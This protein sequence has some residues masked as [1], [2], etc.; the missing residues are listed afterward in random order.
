MDDRE[1]K[2][3]V[4]P[5]GEGKMNWETYPPPR[6]LETI[7]GG[8]EVRWEEDLGVSMHGG[9]A[10]FIEFLNVSGIWKRFVAECPLKY[11]SPNAPTN[12]EILG[13]ILFSVL[14]GHR[15]Y[16]HITRI[17][18]DNVLPGL[19]GI[20]TLRSE[21]SVRRAFEEQKEED[22][23]LWMD[24]Q[25]NETYE[26]LLDQEWILDLDATVK[27][28]YGRQEEAQV[29]Y[30][31]MKPGRPSH[32]YHAMVMTAAKLVIN[33]DAE[34]G[35]RIASAYAQPTLWGWL[36][37]REKK[38]WPTLIRGDIAY[39]NE[40]MMSGC[41]QRGLG[42]LFKLRQ[43]PRVAQMLGS[44]ARNRKAEWHNAGQG[45]EG[46]EQQLQ[47]Q[48]WSVARRV[49]VLRRKIDK[50]RKVAANATQLALP[51]LTLQHRDGEQ[52][53]HAVLVTC[54][55]ERD[56]L[57]VAQTYRDRADAENLFDELKN[58]WGWTGFTTQDLKRS[59]LMARMCALIYNWWTIFTRMG[60]GETHGEAITTR[61]L[62]QQAVVRRTK[63]ANQTRLNISSLHGKAKQAA[64]LLNRISNWLQQFSKIAEQLSPRPGWG[65]MLRQIFQDF[66]RFPIVPRPEE[67]VLVPVNRRI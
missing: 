31:P 27:T 20:K 36:E 19:L 30:N 66:G 25:I 29:G 28:L 64:N 1:A 2:G 39:G 61:P 22:L 56:L 41:E 45:W 52:Y 63:H 23:T 4:H 17:R 34:A 65:A 10:Y 15:R 40:G 3:G 7:G 38:D 26:A 9:L 18:G 16:A 58:Q 33:V 37:S 54:W 59:Q 8:V 11:S 49:I 55:P 6:R 57:A 42:Y 5:K 12:S 44:L 24:R 13:T 46:I 67:G 50:D 48:G 32:V 14:S 51:G 47:L 60:T 53:E 62:L 35:N 21:D 43:S